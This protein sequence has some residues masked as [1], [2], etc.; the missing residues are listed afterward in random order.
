MRNESRIFDTSKNVGFLLLSSFCLLYAVF[1][2]RFAE[3]N[4][5]FSF[6]NFPIFAGEFLLAACAVLLL[7]HWFSSREKFRKWHLLFLLY[8]AWVLVKGFWGYFEWGPL[9]FRNAAL[10]YYPFFAVAGFYFFDAKFFTPKV[11]LLFTLLLAIVYCGFG[12]FGYQAFSFLILYFVLALSFPWRW[13]GILWLLLLPIFFNFPLFFNDSRSHF[14]ALSA[15]LYFLSAFLIWMM[16]RHGHRPRLLA[17]FVSFVILLASFF[18]VPEYADRAFG[19]WQQVRETHQRMEE[20]FRGVEK[21]FRFAA[22]EPKLYSKEKFKEKFTETHD[23]YGPLAVGA[24]EV[25]WRQQYLKQLLIK[26]GEVQTNILFRYYI[27]RDMAQE[28]LSEK[29]VFGLSFGKPQRSKMIEILNWAGGE[30]SR[31][32]WIT[33]HNSWLHY[34]YRGGVMGAALI[35]VFVFL[36]LKMVR[37][38]GREGYA[39]GLLLASIIVYGAVVANFIVY[40]ELPYTAIPFW[41]FFGFL[42]AHARDRRL[43]FSA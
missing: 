4:I 34:L 20:F 1:S 9:A 38:F 26:G 2:V 7:L 13:A 32:G 22:I 23:S 19:K 27:W 33:P 24:A 35:F 31:D 15:A 37:Q 18:W 10:F 28:F 14:I 5:E 29:P 12:F 42:L 30:W 3:L 43:I 17:G 40:L 41:T 21:N 6:L 39:G 8:A 16:V 25:T 11:R 36:F